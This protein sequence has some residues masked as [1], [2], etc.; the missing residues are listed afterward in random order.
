MEADKP[1]MKPLPNVQRTCPDPQFGECSLATPEHSVQLLASDQ[2]I[3]E[4][5]PQKTQVP[6]L[7]CLASKDSGKASKGRTEMGMASD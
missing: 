1:T 2:V 7:T 3:I 4:F 5:P 6:V